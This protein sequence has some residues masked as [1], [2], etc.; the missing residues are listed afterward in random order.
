L[1]VLVVAVVCFALY[2]IFGGGHLLFPILVTLG[3]VIGRAVQLTWNHYRV[4]AW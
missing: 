2:V 3:Y 1:Q 4:T